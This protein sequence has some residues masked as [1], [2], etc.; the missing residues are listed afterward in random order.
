[1]DERVSSPSRRRNGSNSLSELEVR[2]SRQIEQS[3]TEEE[4][5][6]R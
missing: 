4:E 3:F 6:G 1:M 5:S 2:G